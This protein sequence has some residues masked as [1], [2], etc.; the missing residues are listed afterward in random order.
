MNIFS[1]D[2]FVS[3]IQ[4]G[5]TI[6][7]FLK[8]GDD[9]IASCFLEKFP[10]MVRLYRFRSLREFINQSFEIF[11]KHLYSL[12]INF[13][14]PL[15]HTTINFPFN[16]DLKNSL[17]KENFTF[18]DRKNMILPLI[19]FPDQPTP[20]FGSFTT[21]SNISEFASEI[22]NLTIL[23][24]KNSIDALIYPEF[25]EFSSLSST[26]GL[27]NPTNH[28]YNE[29]ASVLLF[30]NDLLIG[31]NLITLDGDDSSIIWQL[32]V[33]P[34]YRRQKLGYK[35]MIKSILALKS[36]DRERLS[37]SVSVGN[38]A[39]LLYESL[40]FIYQND[41]FTVITKNY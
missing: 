33:H 31:V 24:A 9:I 25:S 28:F 12:S 2:T 10:A 36:L 6:F 34:N 20:D 22:I 40:G 13:H 7:F 27:N 29:K 39:A 38:P 17:L 32:A 35:L 18:Y 30:D 3:D 4:S 11:V 37:L 1:S 21:N 15:F 14:V 41:P 16:S 19:S 8:A 23:S 5:K 26:Y